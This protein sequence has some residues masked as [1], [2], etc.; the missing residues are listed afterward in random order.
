MT[1]ETIELQAAI[2]R[3][4]GLH[5]VTAQAVSSVLALT[6]KTERENPYWRFY[7]TGPAGP[8][9]QFENVVL[10]LRR[11][12]TAWSLVWN[13]VGSH[14]PRENELELRRYGPIVS[15]DVNPDIPPEGTQTYS[16]NHRGCKI[17]FQFRAESRLL[18]LVVLAKE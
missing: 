9:G 4:I 7:E 11:D 3:V 12:N 8:S 18:R 10:K 5:S 14:A 1:P 2:D 6:F 13:Y 17:S 15:V 16:F